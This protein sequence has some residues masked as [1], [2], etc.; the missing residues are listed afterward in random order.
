M[1]EET[2]FKRF[3]NIQSNTDADE[4]VDT[5]AMQV[6][7]ICLDK[8]TQELSNPCSIVNIHAIKR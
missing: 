2:S 4:F 8:G 1:K 3:A 5:G 7:E 6:R